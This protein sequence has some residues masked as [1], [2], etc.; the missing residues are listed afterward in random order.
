MPGSVNR[1]V[2][3]TFEASALLALGWSLLLLGAVGLFLPVVPGILLM[4]AGGNILR[5]R[6][7]RV[8]WA[9][10]KCREY[11]RMRIFGAGLG[12]NVPQGGEEPAERSQSIVLSANC[13]FKTPHISGSGADHGTTA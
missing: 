1:E 6:S 11:L 13:G 5:R 3:T 12:S 7:P 9:S 2:Q 4:L 8:F 10:E